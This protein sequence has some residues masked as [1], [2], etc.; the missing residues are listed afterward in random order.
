MRVLPVSGN[1]C[2]PKTHDLKPKQQRI[3]Y[4]PMTAVQ[5][6]EPN[7]QGGGT[8]AAAAIFGTILGGAALVFAAPIAVV[9]GAAVLGAAGG[10]ALAEDDKPMNDVE[11]YKY[12]HE[13]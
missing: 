10:A 13:Y 11:R 4:S 8:A 3:Q 6:N 1:Y 12:T 9:A 7:F 5:K 2:Q